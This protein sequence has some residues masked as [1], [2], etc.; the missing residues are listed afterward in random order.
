MKLFSK[1]TTAIVGIALAAGVGFAASGNKAKAAGA[2]GGTYTKISSESDLTSGANYL[3]VSEADNL[4]FD[5]SLS[6]IDAISNTQAV[7]IS[8]N[9]ITASSDFYFTITSKSGGYSIKGSG[10]L[11]I[12]ST[13][14]N[15]NELKSGTSDSY[16]NTIAWDSDNSC[17]VI[18]GTNSYLV[19]NSSSGQTRFRY[20][21][22]ATCNNGVGT[23]AYHKV[24][25]F[26]EAGGSCT[27]NWVAGTVHNPTC[28]EQ[29]Y[30]EYTCS[31]CSDT[32][33]DDFVAALGHDFGEVIVDTAA[34]C[35]EAGAGHKVCS[36][37]S[38]HTENV[39][40]PATGHNYVDGVCS[41][42]GA[43]EPDPSQIVLAATFTLGEDGAASHADG[44][45]A[46]TYSEVQ[47]DYTLSISDG[48]KL[49][50]DAR[51][52][53][54]NGCLKFGTSSAV[55]SMSI[56]VPSDVV[57]VKIY[58]AG[59]KATDAKISIN[60]GEAQTIST[61]SNDGS[62][63]AVEVDTSGN[64]TIAFTT[65]STGYR[66]M[67][68]TIEFYVVGSGPVCTHDWVAGTVHAAT[69]TEGGYTEYECSLCG[70]TKQDDV[71]AALGHDFGEWQTT[72]EP[73]CTEAGSKQRV[74]SRDSSHTEVEAI[75]A[76][77]H[78]FVDGVCTVCGAEEG[79]DT[80]I[81]LDFTAD[82][83]GISGT[84]GNQT[85]TGDGATYGFEFGAGTGTGAKYNTG[86]VLFGKAGTY[87]RNTSAP[88]N[89]YISAISW[90]YSGTVSTNVQLSLSYGEVALNGESSP[91]TSF[92]KA[93]QNGEVSL[94]QSDTSKAYFFIYVTNAYNCQFK[95]FSVTWTKN[96]TPPTPVTT[97]TVT[98]SVANGS[99]DKASV[100]EGATL[101]TTITPDAKYDLPESVSVT[102]GGVAIAA[103]YTNGVVTVENV[104]GDIVITAEC[105][106]THGLWEDDPYT[107]AE[108]R[109][110]IDAGTNL[111]GAYVSGI[112]SQVDSYNST[113]H[114][115]TY[116]I[117]D[118]GTTTDQLE[119][120]SGKGL[121]GADFSKVEDVEVGATVEVT[122]TLKKYND[123][124]E[125]DKN[126]YLVSYV[127]PVHV[128]PV[129]TLS[130]YKGH[131]GMSEVGLEITCD[132]ESFSGT[133]TF[134]VDGTPSY[135]NVSV[136][137][138]TIT[139]SP[140]AV[141]TETLTVKG[142]YNT[143][144]ASKEFKV[145]VTQHAGSAADPFTVAEAGVVIEAL[146]TIEANVAGIISQVDSYNST[147]HSITYWI[148]D[149]GTTTD[150]LEVYSGKG[151][152]G[153]DFSAVTDVEVGAQ[154]VVTGA[155]KKYND[156][157]E[158]DKNNELVS[159]V[160]PTPVV[161]PEL[162]LSVDEGYFSLD[163][164]MSVLASWE[165]FS[166]DPTL[167]VEGTP[168][169]VNVSFDD[170][171]QV[172]FSAK[173]GGTE[174]VTI[175]ATNGSEVATAT[176]TVVVTE[177]AGTE[178]D[179]YSV[180]DAKLL[181]IKFD[182]ISGTVKGVISQVV[183]DSFSAGSASYYISDDG[184]TTDQLLVTLGKGYGGAD[185]DS[186]SDV[187]VG[188]QV[189]VGG[190][191][192]DGG[193]ASGS[194]IVRLPNAEAFAQTLLDQ[195]DTVCTNSEEPGS[196]KRKLALKNLWK[197]TGAVGAGYEALTATEKHALI[198]SAA[199]EDGSV[200]E[201]AMA[202]Y[203]YLVSAYSLDNIIGR[204]PSSSLVNT[205]T[206]SNEN[207]VSTS[208]A[209]SVV[210]VVAV[211][212]ITTLAVLVVVKKRKATSR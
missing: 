63:T 157:Y 14:S 75:P 112:I 6:T 103:D 125:F 170:A 73:T 149:D 19:Y 153:A 141:G 86:Y 173:A 88:E 154:V 87:F 95:N 143:Q 13:S 83:Y 180:T 8:D 187:A 164:G 156:V 51:D 198:K 56:A 120:Y 42:C 136:S 17:F 81:S 84:Q 110:A 190:T 37:D 32:K 2:A 209:T 202:R 3:I 15:A 107:V 167:S 123:T 1:I 16:T 61:H 127:A 124:Y 152:S 134:S 189:F 62:Y 117:S 196:S 4:A 40:I 121:S 109:A 34:T 145:C 162:S 135:V 181:L 26:K 211:I 70:A 44:S 72:L 28:T 166:A 129:I 163:G 18:R 158:F 197:S 65:V 132:F 161:T 7:T 47:G 128:D 11:Y 66:C 146:E 71:T 177:H 43:I 99:L 133:P 100:N 68:N 114:S 29:G 138:S 77:G 151:L 78:N 126:N 147:Y 39:V 139:L 36:R 60:G 57:S 92:G 96:S 102:M 131:L 115:I 33:N 54:G 25:L 207:S 203:D 144:E 122:G 21:K 165:G 101:T 59:Y 188:T 79:S 80:T 168:S 12:G 169:C 53:T 176:F 182:N 82:S 201:Q 74:C 104:T 90:T 98:D 20:Y 46:T 9:S 41:V 85:L 160:G 159:Y 24:S 208:V 210:I 31:L 148:S 52:A 130:A 212:S 195:T 175:K 111:S 178:A 116:W 194:S 97:Y 58:V 27:H 119:V 48:V 172:Y 69:C 10:G 179:P 55:G 108:A 199:K 5:G 38:S 174:T 137:G 93:T 30:T 183:S 94:T 191:L 140:K 106:K 206:I 22:P 118:D 23:G 184:T 155:L 186:I 142:V 171:P 204:T 193:F 113:Y 35:T 49:S 50:K 67:V 89:S 185:F 76:T 105:G 205:Q 150:Q 200:V 64:K 45:S 192:F 91:I